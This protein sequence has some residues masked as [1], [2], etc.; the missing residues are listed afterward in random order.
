MLRD[1]HAFR[2]IRL[3]KPP[4]H[5]QVAFTVVSVS[6]TFAIE[7]RS[8]NCFATLVWKQVAGRVCWE[9]FGTPELRA[10]TA[11]IETISSTFRV[12]HAA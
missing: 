7:N 11:H 1:C 12:D 10:S 4:S 3:A 6:A 8:M 5:V 9:Q 2:G